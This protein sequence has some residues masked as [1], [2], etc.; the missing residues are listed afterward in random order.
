MSNVCL[1]FFA[2]IFTFC[3]NLAEMCKFHRYFIDVLSKSNNIV[4]LMFQRGE[5]E[6]KNILRT[7]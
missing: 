6:V 4:I 1:L 3:A 5:A 2:V 7:P